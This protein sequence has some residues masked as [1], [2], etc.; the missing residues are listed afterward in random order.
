ML[1]YDANM[2]TRVPKPSSDEPDFIPEGPELDALIKAK[3]AQALAD[4]RPPVPLEE[5]IA[6]VHA[7]IDA[8][9]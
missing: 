9:A 7:R 6:R 4:P 3:V 1:G 5:A 2:A 8:A